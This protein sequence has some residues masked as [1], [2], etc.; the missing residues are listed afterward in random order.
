MT[1]P[2]VR[3]LPVVRV[4]RLQPTVAKVG[5]IDV[6]VLQR[7]LERGVQGDVLFDDGSRGLYAQDASN[8]FEVPIGVVLP[9][10]RADVAVTLAACRA[11]GAPVV[12]RTGG[13]AL[14][15][16]TCNRAVIID[17]SKYMNRIL[18]LDVSARRAR[19]EPGLVCDDLV[20]AAKPH[21]LTWGPKPAT[22]DRCC[23]G[24]MLANNCGGMEAQRHG[25]AVHNVESLDVLLYDGTELHLG[26]MTDAEFVEAGRR[27][28]RA[29]AIFRSLKELRD[30]VGG[31]VRER[32][33]EIPRRV[34]GYNLDELLPKED[35][36]LNVARALVGTEGTCAVIVEANLHLLPVPPYQIVVTAGFSDVYAAGAA[37]PTVL[38][39]EP[40]ICEG[41]DEILVQNIVR[42]G[43]RNERYLP[44]LPKGKGWLIVKLGADSH[45]EARDKA[46]AL[47]ARLKDHHQCQEVRVVDD[48]EHEQSLWKVRES[49]LGATAF[50][51]GLPDTWPGWEDS[52][53]AP[54]RLADY[55][56]DLRE[57]FSRYGYHPSLYG[58][59]GQGLVHCRV[60]FDLVSSAGIENY[61]AFAREAADLCAG[62]YGGSLSGEHGDGQSRAW[63]LERMFGPELVQA[64]GEFKAIWDPHG[65]M[66][67]GKLVNP[68]PVD[69]NL[70]LGAS[71][72]PWEPKTHFQFPEDH[73][74]FSRATLRCVGVGKC[75]RHDASGEAPEDVMC[76]S[77]MVTRDE[78]HSTRGR[79]HLLWEMMRGD[80]SPIDRS[81]RNEH[82]KEA[83]DLCLS[84]K[85]CKGDCP[86]NVDVA[87][88]K[89][90]FLSHYWQGR[91]RPRY[92]YAF[93]FIDKWARV[94]SIAPGFVNLLTHSKPT[95]W[96]AKLAAGMTPEKEA[97]RF[98]AQ[99]FLSWYR[100]NWSP[101]PG[102][103]R[104]RRAVLFP[105]TFNNHFHP[106]T[107]RAALEVLDSAGYEVIV[108]DRP[109]CCGRPL[110]D[111]GFL[112]EARVYLERVMDGLRPWIDEELPIVVLEPSCASVFRDEL[113]NLLP[114]R[115]EGKRLSRQTKLLSELLAEDDKATLP[116]LHRKAIVQGHCHHKSVLDYDPERQVLERMELDA[117]LLSSGCCGMAGSF[118]FER[119]EAKQQVSNACGER[120]LLPAV[121][122]ESLETL[123]IANGFSC[124]TQI[125]QG[126]RRRALHLADVL[127][128]ALEFGVSG[129][130]AGYVESSAP[131]VRAPERRAAMVLASLAVGT[132]AAWLGVA[133]TRNRRARGLGR[134]LGKRAR[135]VR[136][137]TRAF[138]SVF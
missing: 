46:D 69:A 58:H 107:A 59:F 105:D 94:A 22:H 3:S 6:G 62:K 21:G 77:Y 45:A 101:K 97:P 4:G 109:V 16:Q 47:A 36:R 67:P 70:R 136:R 66:N 53:V 24:G 92:A 34:S 31:L 1:E 74:S 39:F 26:W 13:T 88:Y 30:R 85:G 37:V 65:K 90:E 83:L 79:A 57:L 98:A 91:V 76:P 100:Q 96:L 108:P 48:P 8:Y 44:L 99:T 112:D 89:A 138:V 86:V 50:V 135:A 51:P 25:I 131:D 7:E 116:L 71:Y 32:Y 5:E 10:S 133:L 54:A 82:V 118:G 68:K 20:H 17:F 73:G 137:K 2:L 128:L 60:A 27:E 113:P 78:K 56:R 120:V 11:Y 15:G 125:S 124:R 121:R 33:P 81:F 84:C 49:G 87:T 43:G 28:G 29:G 127:K 111:Y 9:R 95:A 41:M 134:R 19:V 122:K 114:T 40:M 117:K 23:F 119:D 12:C 129:P 80:G 93:G 55:L 14:A 64:F 35:G 126:S 72:D 130:P 104:T 52:S 75:R 106:E 63:L 103:A 110:Y 42:K 132:A 115:M 102:R 18:E 38:E 123:V 61:K